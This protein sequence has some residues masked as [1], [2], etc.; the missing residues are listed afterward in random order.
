MMKA[1]PWREIA[2]FID[3]VYAKSPWFGK[4]PNQP[5]EVYWY[6]GL[7][8]SKMSFEEASNIVYTEL[9]YGAQMIIDFILDL[10]ILIDSI[11]VSIMIG[12]AIGE[13]I[14]EWEWGL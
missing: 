3:I 2:N 13:L 9:T 7:W 14:C 5:I 6:N 8:V 11:V 4:E 10:Y 12:A 1:D